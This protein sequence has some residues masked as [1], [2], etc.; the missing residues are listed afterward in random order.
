MGFGIASVMAFPSNT[1]SSTISLVAIKDE[2]M[3]I[4]NEVAEQLYQAWLEKQ[5]PV[6][7]IAGTVLKSIVIDPGPYMYNG[8]CSCVK[9]ARA[10]SGINV[11]PVG[12]AKN[13]P[14]NRI[15]P[16]IGGLFITY[17][18]PSGHMGIVIG[19]EGNEFIG[20]DFNYESCTK[21]IRKLPIDSPLIK[22]YYY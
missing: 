1:T 22:G 13:H 15:L 4:N 11:G 7:N 19:I 6:V 18:G 12:N 5:K 2:P 16:V 17:E 3:E 21:T 20:E 14:T 9:Y 8:L 10:I